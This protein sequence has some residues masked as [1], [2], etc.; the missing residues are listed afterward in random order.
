MIGGAKCPAA[1]YVSN[2]RRRHPKKEVE[3][4]LRYAEDH[5]WAVIPTTGRTDASSRPTASYVLI[6]HDRFGMQ[7]H[8][9]ASQEGLQ[10]QPPE[11]HGKRKATVQLPNRLVDPLRGRATEQGV[12]LGEV[13]VSAYVNHIRTV[14]AELAAPDDDPRVELGL[15][16]QP[17]ERRRRPADLRERPT[18]VGLYLPQTAYEVLDRTATELGVSRSYL[19]TMLLDL[20]LSRAASGHDVE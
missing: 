1:L 16:P 11:P 15:P 19:V 18:Q 2:M 4:A 5:G 6:G 12:V 10:P 3:E 9:R 14:E 20:E 8:S 17:R 13:I 7:G